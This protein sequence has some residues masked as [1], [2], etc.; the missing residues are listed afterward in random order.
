M[1]IQLIRHGKTNGNEE[2]K[3]VGRTD[4]EV[5]VDGLNALHKQEKIAADMVFCSPK[6]RCLQTAEILIESYNTFEVCENLAECDFGDF[7]NKN[8]LELQTDPRYV[9]WVDGGCKG[10]IPNG[11]SMASF[12]QRT[13]DE[14]FRCLKKACK[15]GGKKI[16]IVAHG[17]SFMAIMAHIFGGE[18]YSYLPK[19]GEGFTLEMYCDQ[20]GLQFDQI[21]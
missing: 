8:Y 18:F 4:E 12:S 6:K 7:E 19:N 3:Y 13:V 11:E 17:G 1:I 15:A 20:D 14:F 21:K 9:A 5:S 16:A 2:G 10:E